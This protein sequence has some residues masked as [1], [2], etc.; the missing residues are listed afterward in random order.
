MFSANSNRFATFGV[1]S[2]VPGAIIDEFWSIIDN[3]LQG[4]FPL[5]NLLR[6]DLLDKDG[7]L[8]IHFSEEEL[9][10]Q[11]AFDTDYEFKDTYPET[12]FAYDDGKAQT[13]LLPEEANEQ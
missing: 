2:K 1:I 5:K 6:F 13:I 11:L 8:Q 7:K 9:N 3:N 10:T 4:V 12:V